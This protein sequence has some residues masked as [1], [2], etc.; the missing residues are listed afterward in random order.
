MNTDTIKNEL[1]TAEKSTKAEL[2]EL[3]TAKDIRDCYGIGMSDCYALFRSKNFP[4]FRLGRKYFISV[5]NLLR[6]ERSCVEQAG[7][8]LY[9]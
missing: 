7:K 2:S 4:S 1:N 9:A 3:L 6:Y 8:R 5:D